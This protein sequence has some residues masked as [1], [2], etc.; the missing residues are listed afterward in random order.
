MKYIFAILLFFLAYRLHKW[1]GYEKGQAD[2]LHWRPIHA[3][4]VINILV[5]LIT[6][7]LFIS[8]ILIL[9]KF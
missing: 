1:Y 8:G 3:N 2:P 4:N 7:G 6:L 9:I 5:N